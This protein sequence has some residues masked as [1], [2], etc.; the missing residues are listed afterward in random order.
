MDIAVLSSTTCI[1]IG[2]DVNQSM[3]D[4]I[5][6]GAT[7]SFSAEQEEHF[8]RRYAEGYNLLIDP[9]YVECMKLNHP[10]SDLLVNS[11]VAVCPGP[12][13]RDEHTDHSANLQ[14]DASGNYA[15]T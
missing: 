10:E 6:S 11:S 9:D 12:N 4:D 15:D 7:R 8:Q 2:L 13:D 14:S 3:C 1:P 5:G